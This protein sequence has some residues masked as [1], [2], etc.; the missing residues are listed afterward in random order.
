MAREA[1]A[2]ARHD[3]PGLVAR[4]Q[5][6]L[7]LEAPYFM[8]RIVYYGFPT[9]RVIGGIKMIYRHVETLRDLGFDAVF[10]TGPD[11]QE[12]AWLEVSVPLARSLALRDDDILVLP[13]D[14]RQVIAQAATRQQKSVIFCQN[15]FI[16]GSLALPSLDI[17]A[18]ARPVTFIAVGRLLAGVIGRVYP[19]AEVEIIPCFA[20]ER[21][22]SPAGPRDGGIAFVPKKRALE[23]K[24]IQGFWRK[25]HP[26]QP[27][28]PWR[29]VSG[30]PET[31]VAEAFRRSELYLSLSRFESVGMATL[32]AMASGCVCAGFTGVGGDEYA[33]PA[34][35]FWVRDDDCEAATD[36]LARAS[37]LVRT[38]G[39]ALR[40]HIEAARSTADAWSYARFRVA[41]EDVW[42]RLAPEARIQSGPLD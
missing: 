34:N 38:G 17:Y 27:E 30:L 20:D 33:S 1:Y 28:R 29:E 40:R 2:L 13:E 36:A 25:F 4:P 35:G 37:D 32:E 24:V 5:L 42:M 23:P 41:L 21:R 10:A 31:Q 14:G 26:D 15:Q 11:A 7:S 6:L 39:P 16:L 9:G 22:F 12:P 19:Q 8:A 3:A 18:A